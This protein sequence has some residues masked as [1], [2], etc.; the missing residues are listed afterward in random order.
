MT[1]SHTK[2]AGVSPGCYRAIM[3][4]SFFYL[5][6][7]EEDVPVIRSWMIGMER[8]DKPMDFFE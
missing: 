5:L 2:L 6:A 7:V 8:L 3:K 4:I 1:P